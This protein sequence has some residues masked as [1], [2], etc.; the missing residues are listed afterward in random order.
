M[1]KRIR[2][3][4]PVRSRSELLAALVWAGL[5]FVAVQA[6][7]EDGSFQSQIL[8]AFFTKPQG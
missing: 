5:V 8:A 7:A 2:T 4:A 6:A 3:G 1:M